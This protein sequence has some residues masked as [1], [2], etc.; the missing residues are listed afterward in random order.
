MSPTGLRLL[1]ALLLPLA[2]AAAPPPEHLRDTGLYADASMQA[3]APGVIEF[4]PRH[5]LWSDGSAKRRW[6]R[7]PAGRFVDASNPDAWRFP[8]GTRL[9]KEF[10]FGA[11]VETRVITLGADGRWQFAIYRGAADGR[12]ATLVP[13]AGA[14][15][16]PAEGAPG[17][18]WDLPSQDDCRACHADARVPV[19]GFGALQLGELLPQLVQ[20]GLVRHGPPAWRE[21]APEIVAADDTERAARGYLHGNCGHCHHAGGVPVP[22]VLAQDVAGTPAPSPEQL[23]KALRR[24]GTRQPLMQMPPLG[25]HLADP[26]GLALVQA[27]SDA[28]EAP[29]AMP[30]LAAHDSLSKP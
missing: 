27:W 5:P 6:I 9:W 13:A 15:G 1:L 12:D 4:T 11:R 29:Q 8:R 14:R 17:G 26:R 23:A 30:P 16:V 20:R 21:R 25:T 19:L 3:T 18:R 28:L 2:A 24:M 22:L 7:L 10:A